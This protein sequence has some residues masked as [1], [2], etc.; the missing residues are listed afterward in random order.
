MRQ[1]DAFLIAMW[2]VL[3]L[4]FWTVFVVALAT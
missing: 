2:L 3:L 4:G 1:D